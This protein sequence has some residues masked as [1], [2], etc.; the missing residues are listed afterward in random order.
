MEQAFYA[1]QQSRMPCLQ[2]IVPQDP[3]LWGMG[4]PNPAVGDTEAH[5]LVAE[6]LKQPLPRRKAGGF[7]CFGGRLWVFWRRFC[8]SIPKTGFYNCLNRT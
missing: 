8:E 1:Q 5:P 7:L 6:N 2:Q 4:I 3:K